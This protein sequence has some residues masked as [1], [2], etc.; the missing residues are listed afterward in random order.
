MAE[1]DYS[2][3]AEDHMCFEFPLPLIEFNGTESPEFD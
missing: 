2:S 1:S 3:G